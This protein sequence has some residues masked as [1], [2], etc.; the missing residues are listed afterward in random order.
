MADLLA[1]QRG[2]QRHH[3]RLASAPGIADL[4]EGVVV[5]GHRSNWWHVQTPA[6]AS[7]DV[8]TLWAELYRRDW[9]ILE[10]RSEAASLEDLYLHH[11]G[12][13]RPYTREA[14]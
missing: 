8:S 5:L 4:P 2:V 7:E 1:R 6:D 12:Q 13:D 14:A 3:L 10:I 11:T 9:R